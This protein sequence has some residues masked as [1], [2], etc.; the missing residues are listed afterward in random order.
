MPT[1]AYE[2]IVRLLVL[3]HYI[4]LHCFPIELCYFFLFIVSAQNM[5]NGNL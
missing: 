1:Y 3:F 4:P 2:S 5:T